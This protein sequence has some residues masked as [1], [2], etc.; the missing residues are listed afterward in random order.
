MITVYPRQTATDF[1]KNA[2]RSQQQRGGHQEPALSRSADT[3]EYVAQK[4]LEA[5][6]NEPAEQYVA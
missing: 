2:R 1:G 5:A 3:P 6:Q 4:I